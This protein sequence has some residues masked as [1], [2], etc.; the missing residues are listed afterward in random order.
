MTWILKECGKL[1][2]TELKNNCPP[3]HL[4]TALSS[5]DLLK[6]TVTILTS[7]LISTVPAFFFAQLEIN[8]WQWRLVMRL[9]SAGN[10]VVRRYNNRSHKGLIGV[11]MY[12]SYKY[13]KASDL[14]ANTNPVLAM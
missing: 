12:R 7:F 1:C 6:M 4:T 13:S 3:V 14:C 10:H 9:E 11:T 2:A 8:I 5:N